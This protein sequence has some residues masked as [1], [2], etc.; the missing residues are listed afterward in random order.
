MA[1]RRNVAGASLALLA[2]AALGAPPS[3][4][5]A[6]EPVTVGETPNPPA[7]PDPHTLAAQIFE[8]AGRAQDRRAFEYAC[9]K[10]AKV[11]ELEPAKVGAKLALAEC[12]AQAGKLASALA[13]YRAAAARAAEVGDPRQKYAEERAAELEA[14]APRVN[15]EVP[16]TLR[17]LPGLTVLRDGAALE[18]SQ[19]N[20]AVPTDPGEHT[21]SVAAPG[22]K[23]W[24][25]KVTVTAGAIA[26]IVIGGLED[27]F[28]MGETP[29]PA[30]P[31]VAPGPDPTGGE[32]L[33]APSRKVPVWAW[34][35]GGL[36]LAAGGVAVGFAVD[37]AAAQRGFDAQ[38]KSSPGNM[39]CGDRTAR[40]WRDF[41]LWIGLGTASVAWLTGATV[42]I[43][44]APRHAAPAP[45]RASF[46]IDPHGSGAA[47]LGHF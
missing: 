5:Q 14:K 3:T 42:G 28:T 6:D 8:E 20:Q 40:L 46:W 21:I 44:T 33:G 2:F 12:Y 32:Q 35:S 13:A 37:Q 25:G 10:F 43:A 15:V 17:S 41:G 45:I 36:G 38:C 9:P 18:A 1:S 23:P 26:Q 29:K 19:W 31:S 39:G 4:A 24:S 47:L 22:K 11:V 16:G 30:P 34:V 7:Q 27:A